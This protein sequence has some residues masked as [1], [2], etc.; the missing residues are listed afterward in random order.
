L[1]HIGPDQFLGRDDFPRS[2]AA[3]TRGGPP[4]KIV[5]WPLTMMLSSDIAGHI[6]AAADAGSLTIAICGTPSVT[7]FA[8]R[9]IEDATENARG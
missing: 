2:G 8:W 1:C 5:P 7:K 3:C 9:I 6:G 4:R